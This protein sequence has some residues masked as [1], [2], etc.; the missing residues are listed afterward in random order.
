[1]K[2]KHTNKE[3]RAIL[4]MHWKQKAKHVVKKYIVCSFRNNF[5][6]T[7]KEASVCERIEKKPWIGKI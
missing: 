4:V 6:E 2:I 5:C 3:L 7:C 1:M